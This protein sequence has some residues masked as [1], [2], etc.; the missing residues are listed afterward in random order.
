M[1][2][3]KKKITSVGEDVEKSEPLCMAGENIKWCS[4]CEKGMVVPPKK[5]N[6]ELPS[7]PII[8]LLDIYKKE[9]K[10]ATQIAICI[11]TFTATLFTMANDKWINKM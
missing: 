2:K 8:P 7:D 1:K 11:P 6:V 9:L 4:F 5:L 10:A 3:K